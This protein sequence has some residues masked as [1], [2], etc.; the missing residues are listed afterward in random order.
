MDFFEQ[1]KN[2]TVDVAQTVA[3]K[4][5]EVVEIS[6][7]KYAIFDLNNDIKKLYS[8]IGKLVYLEAGDS[9]EYS[10]G[11]LMKCEIIRAKKAKIASLNAKAERV[12]TGNSFTCPDCG[13]ECGDADSACPYC[14]GDMTVEVVGEVPHITIEEDGEENN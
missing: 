7:I 1:V 3:Q 10:E 11:V 12:K 2:K 14:G 13:R 5:G 4:S 9:T 6:K 8:E